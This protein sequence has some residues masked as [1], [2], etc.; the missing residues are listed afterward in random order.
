MKAYVQPLTTLESDKLYRYYIGEEIALARFSQDKRHVQLLVPRTREKVEIASSIDFQV[1]D[2]NLGSKDCHEEK[3]V[4]TWHIEEYPNLLNCALQFIGSNRVVGFPTSS[5]MHLYHAE[6][7]DED[8][9]GVKPV[10]VSRLPMDSKTTQRRRPWNLV[11]KN[12]TVHC[13]SQWYPNIAVGILE[14]SSSG[15]HCRMHASHPNVPRAFSFFGATA[16][17]IAYREDLWFL[18]RVDTLTAY[19]MV[20][21]GPDF[22]LKAFTPPFIMERGSV[23]EANDVQTN[24]RFMGFDILRQ[25]DGQDFI[26]FV[27]SVGADVVVRRFAVEEVL[28]QMI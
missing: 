7:H 4:W 8:D 17:G 16:H 13:V 22:A 12:G 19:V 21:L 18:L 5:E 20:V 26:V 3:G 25:E 9:S 2:V 15:A 27:Y 23:R 24:D 14:T 6:W 10:H 28:V 1:L 11:E